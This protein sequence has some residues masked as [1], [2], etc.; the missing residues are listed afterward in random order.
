[1][2]ICAVAKVGLGCV[3]VSNAH[4]QRMCC[5]AAKQSSSSQNIKAAAAMRGNL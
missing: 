1:M 2:Y 3:R 4:T 5:R